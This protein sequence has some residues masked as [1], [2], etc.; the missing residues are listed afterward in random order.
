MKKI[1]LILALIVPQT[2]LAAT[3]DDDTFSFSNSDKQLHMISSYGL[4]YTITDGFRR[5]K[6]SHWESLLYGSLA[7]L[8]VGTLKELTDD[9]FSSNDMLANGIGV[10]VSAGVVITFESLGM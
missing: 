1:L 2:G 8:A 6:Y 7:T 3:A 9:D 10:A 4:A 5:A